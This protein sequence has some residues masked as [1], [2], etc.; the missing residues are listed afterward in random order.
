[1]T[2]PEI[3]AT[4]STT[5]K[6]R[7]ARHAN[8][9]GNTSMSQS[10]APAVATS[11]PAS[12]TAIQPPGAKSSGSTV[13]QA[14]HADAAA[15]GSA[16]PMK[17]AEGAPSILVVPLPISGGR[18]VGANR[19][20]CAPRKHVH[21]VPLKAA[22]APSV[23]TANSPPPR[24]PAMSLSPLES[25]SLPAPSLP[26][27]LSTTC[28][29]PSFPPH[30]SPSP[31][32]SEEVTLEAKPAQSLVFLKTHSPL[33]ANLMLS[34]THLQF[35]GKQVTVKAYASNPPISCLGVIHNVGGHFTS[36]QL[37]NDLESFTTDIL[38]ARMM[39]TTESVLITFSGTIIPRFVYFKRVSFRC[40]PHKPKPP[41]CTHCL[42]L[43]HRAHQ[44]PQHS[45]S[46]KCRRCAV[47]LTTGPTAHV[48]AQLWCIHCQVNTHS[49]LDPTCPFL[50]AKQRECAKAALYDLLSA[51]VSTARLSLPF[52]PLPFLRRTAMRRATQPP[53]SSSSSI[54][55]S[56]STSA[57]SPPGSYAAVVKAPSALSHSSS[58]NTPPLSLTNE[59]RSFDLRPAMLERNQ[60]EQQSVS[61]GM[62]QEIHSPTQTLQATTSCL[63]S[64][65]TELN[66]QLSV[67]SRLV[68]IM[69]DR[70][71]AGLQERRLLGCVNLLVVSD[72][73]MASPSCDQVIALE[74]FIDPGSVYSLVGLTARLRPKQPGDVAQLPIVLDIDSGYLV[75]YREADK[76]PA[77]CNGGSHGYN[78]APGMQ[79]LFVAHGPAFRQNVTSRP[80]RNIEL[81]ELMTELLNIAANPNNGTRKALLYLLRKPG[82][83]PEVP[84]LKT[85]GMCDVEGSSKFNDGDNEDGLPSQED[86]EAESEMSPCVFSNREYVMAFDRAIRLPLWTAFTLDGK[87]EHA[88]ANACWECEARLKGADR[89]CHDYEILA[90]RSLTKEPLFPPELA[91]S[92]AE[93]SAV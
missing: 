62:Q 43:G 56:A 58:S 50:L 79:S 64:Q 63:T 80:F 5:A 49:S 93:Q 72:H 42:A 52:L 85:P 67:R 16:F 74:H 7:A 1:M 14:T 28:S 71:V 77:L 15:S 29:T 4:R 65:L 6:L 8:N 55:E 23:L 40:R 32:D 17:V 86:V 48:C 61:H 33:T 59:N 69:L 60:L 82:A 9:L 89:S 39:G 26:S 75:L 41:T 76:N 22:A 30:D 13:K 24:D 27:C 83:L 38:G 19:F 91:S 34:L 45:T 12:F 21:H 84:P 36:S 68:E 87:Y 57:P 47:P 11:E 51:I 37:L 53:P 35:H 44:F 20:H 3:V 31:K 46:A 73:G 18:L 10:A 81:Y 78:M 66:K 90:T 92:L 70:L 2:Q 88:I 54:R 25:S